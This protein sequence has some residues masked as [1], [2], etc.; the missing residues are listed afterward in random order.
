MTTDELK[1]K[2]RNVPDFPIKGVMFRDITT[3]VKD[4]VAFKYVI[5]HLYERYKNKKIDQIIGIESR[6]FIFGGALAH[7]L[8]C[9][10]VPARK[11]GKLPGE[12]IEE[13]YELEYGRTSLQL[14]TDAI[15]KGDRVLVL[16]DLLATGGT[17]R[18]TTNMVER[19]GGTIVE[20]AVVIE[21]SFL[22]GRDKL[23][24]YNIYAMLDYDSE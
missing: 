14:H 19:L 3:L 18:A 6:G 9:G 4:K 15:K 23:K 24:N 8:G 21:L 5:D 16:D 11:P 10:F 22:K 1:N 7:R 2:I 13:S 17:I 20:I 12:T